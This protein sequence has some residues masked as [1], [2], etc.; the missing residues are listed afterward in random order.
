MQKIQSLGETG[1]NVLKRSI[2]AGQIPSLFT[3][4][5]TPYMITGPWNLPAVQKSGVQVRH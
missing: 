1:Q 3:D 2:E 5:K 4:Q